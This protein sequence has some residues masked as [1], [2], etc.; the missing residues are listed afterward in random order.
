MMMS[1][2]NG[3]GESSVK[4]AKRELRWLRAARAAA[5]W[6]PVRNVGTAERVVSAGLGAAAIALG[7]RKGTGPAGLSLSALGAA[8]LARGATGYCPVSHAVGRKPRRA[9]EYDVARADAKLSRR[10]AK[11][12][13]RVEEASRE[14]FPASDA[15]GWTDARA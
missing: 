12:H 11:A 7:L 3:P 13:D 8:L 6:M 5:T 1:S 14:S 4:T 10:H 2:R 9:A 15:P